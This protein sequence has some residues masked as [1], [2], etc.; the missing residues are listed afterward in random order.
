MQFIEI[1]IYFISLKIPY[2]S[3]RQNIKLR[4]KLKEIRLEEIIRATLYDRNSPI[5][6][7]LCHLIQ[8][9]K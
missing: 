1:N 9:N 6:E 5:K 8:T 7:S 2:N 3:L 4:L